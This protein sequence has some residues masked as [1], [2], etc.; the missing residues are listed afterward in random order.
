MDRRTFVRIA[1]TLAGGG[2]LTA[3]G[4]DAAPDAASQPSPSLSP[5]PT[6]NP[7][8]Q[9]APDA[10]QSLSVV[11][12]S[13]E[14]LVGADQPFA[15]GL[16]GDGNTPVTGADVEVYVVPVDGQ[17]TGPFPASFHEVENVAPGVY[18]SQLDIPAPGTT[19]FVVV[20]ADG[21]RGGS[22]TLNV[23]TPEASALIAPGTEAIS[24]QTPTDA[25]PM[26]V[27]QLCTRD[28]DCGMHDVSLDAA[29]RE[30]RPVVLTFATPAYCQTAVCGPSVSVLEQVRTSQDWGDV[31]FMHCEVYADE[32]QTVTQAVADWKLPSEPWLF[33]I[34]R[35]GVVAARADGPRLVLD[36]QVGAM[37]E[38]V[39]TKEAP[40]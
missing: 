22:D 3:C 17:P 16:F 37:V 19:S 12:A 13:F 28:P 32:G 36:D 10:Q 34:D 18:L 39:A 8:A 4:A 25:N 31:A 33:T 15:F 5:Q 27:A 35:E 11:S 40:S 30:G 21:A 38:M 6:F 29:L 26:G 20:T 9:V 14:Q 2:L 24:T 23:V 7:L 1:A